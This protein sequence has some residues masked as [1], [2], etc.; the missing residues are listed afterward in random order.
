MEQ[1]IVQRESN[2]TFYA[3][4]AAAIRGRGPLALLRNIATLAR[5]TLAARRLLRK[6]RPMAILGTGGYVCVPLFVAARAARIP[7]LLYLPD[8]VPGFAVRFLA[9]LATRVACNVE[10]S[11]RYLPA[12]RKEQALLVTGYPVRATLFQQDR[13][14]CRV[15]F[16]LSGDGTGNTTDDLPVLL[17]YGGSRGARSINR[18][19]ERLLPD[20]LALA[21]I[22]HV[23]GREGDE[24]WLRV[25]ADRLEPV[26]QARYR[27]Y[28]Y[29][30]DTTPGTMV[31]AFGAADLAL[32]RSGAST[33]AELPAA[34]L[35]A[36]L[37]PYP[38]VHQDEN[39]DHLVRHGAAIKVPDA[40]M[41]PTEGDASQGTLMH[42]LHRLLTNVAERQQ[43]AQQCRALAR[44]DAA[45]RLAD[46]LCDL[47]TRKD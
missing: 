39:A 37:V 21:H 15:A 19:I 6:L 38:Y 14:A 17:V 10:E 46:A 29:L 12:Q 30:D 1:E 18:A 44:P 27:L 40:T 45:A 5:G 20:I 34:G 41:L 22:I 42:A 26:L 28:P 23:C 2:L 3:L 4:P 24:I 43:M 36:I 25:A 11:R 32:C 33:L 13:A 9:R 16:G 7:T 31:Q 35:P 8:V 47:A